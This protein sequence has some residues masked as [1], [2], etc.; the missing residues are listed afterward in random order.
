MQTIR[1]ESNGNVRKIWEDKDRELGATPIRASHIVVTEEGP[2]QGKFHVDLSPIAKHIQKPEFAVC[3]IQ[4]F[5]SYAEANRFEVEWL[6]E[7]YIL[8][9]L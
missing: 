6:T 4:Q 8:A 5:D 2:N 1:F 7:N 9:E 3:L